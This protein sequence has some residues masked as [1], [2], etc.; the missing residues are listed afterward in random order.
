M[1]KDIILLIL[2]LTTLSASQEIW[3]DG[4]AMTN[5][6]IEILREIRARMKRTSTNIPVKPCKLSFLFW[7]IRS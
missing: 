2:L 4:S 3:I 6:R 5:Q 1:N 7:C